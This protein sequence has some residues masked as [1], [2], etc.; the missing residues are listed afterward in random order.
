LENWAIF[1]PFPIHPR[2]S[3]EIHESD[4]SLQKALEI[5]GLKLRR[6]ENTT[7]TSLAL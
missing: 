5:L 3:K 2:G 6:L 4:E 7:L 1:E